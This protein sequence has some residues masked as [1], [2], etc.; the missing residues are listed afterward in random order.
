MKSSYQTILIC[1]I[2]FP[3]FLATSCTQKK[4]TVPTKSNVDESFGVLEIKTQISEYIRNIIQDKNGHLWFG[5][6]GDGI[7]H[8]DGQGI[9][10][11]SNAEGFGGGQITGISEDRDNNL[12]F[13]T[14]QGV[15]KY[16]LDGQSA[17]QKVFTNY[18]GSEYFKDHQFWSI[19]AD[20]KGY[21]WAGSAKS[22]YRFDGI[23]WKPFDLPYP[24]SENGDFI[25]ATTT[26]S[27][28]EDNK[29]N[30]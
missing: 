9:S 14:D 12:W 2:V 25:T 11:F 13:A 4:N 6:N 3:L 22:I 20:S 19:C 26:W 24:K 15:V 30:I 28:S 17:D 21:I 29:G 8:Y 18:N 10:Y 7:A 27:I 5:T 16:N 1:L 23:F